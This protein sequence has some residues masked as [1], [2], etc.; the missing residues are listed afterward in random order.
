MKNTSKRTENQ[1]EF[2]DFCNVCKKKRKFQVN[3]N[4]YKKEVIGNVSVLVEI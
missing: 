3:I 1:I 4:D 2:E